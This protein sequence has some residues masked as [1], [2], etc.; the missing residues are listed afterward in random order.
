MRAQARAT[1][2][3]PGVAPW[4][5][6]LSAVVGRCR[7]FPG[8][9]RVASAIVGRDVAANGARATMGCS[10]GLERASGDS[11]SAHTFSARDRSAPE[12]EKAASETEKS[13]Q[14]AAL[15]ARF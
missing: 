11:S 13:G 5:R 7:P 4:F 10:V 14:E 8:G 3:H 1:P 15:W 2:E 9:F 12:T 6:P